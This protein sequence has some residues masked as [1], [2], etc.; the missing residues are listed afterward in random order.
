MSRD[1]MKTQKKMGGIHSS[2]HAGSMNTPTKANS[3]KSS[4]GNKSYEKTNNEQSLYSPKELFKSNYN[5]KK[6]DL[7][8]PSK[9]ETKGTKLDEVY[10]ENKFV[11]TM[12]QPLKCYEHKITLDSPYRDGGKNLRYASPNYVSNAVFYD[13]NT[14]FSINKNDMYR[15]ST[16]RFFTPPKS[17]IDN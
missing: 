2:K 17:K 8:L 12:Q 1:N 3:K 10:I 5:L 14:N 16:Q 4:Y 11:K 9:Y 15:T 7:F 13:Q 6:S